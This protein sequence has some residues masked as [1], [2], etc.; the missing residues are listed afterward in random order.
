MKALI[1]ALL[2]GAAA[3]CAP[4]LTD[5]GPVAENDQCHASQYKF[6]LG[7][8]DDEIPPTPKGAVWRVTCTTCA[9][10]MD[11]APTRLNIFYEEDTRVIKQVKCG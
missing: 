3:A 4:A 10:T 9:V 8:K 11:Y 5:P 1:A 2:V 7:R 6:L